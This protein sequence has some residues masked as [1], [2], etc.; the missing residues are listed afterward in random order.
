MTMDRIG[1]STTTYSL[2]PSE[3]NLATALGGDV[4]AQIAASMLHSARE[5][6]DAASDARHA[7]EAQIAKEEKEQ[8]R[9]MREQ[10]DRIRSAGY[11][12]AGSAFVGSGLQFVGAALGPET[13]TGKSLHAGGDMT[14]AAGQVFATSDR[15][16]ASIHEQGATRAEQIADTEKRSFS[17]IDAATDEARDLARTALDMLRDARQGENE[18]NRSTLYL[19]G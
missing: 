7:T 19:R 16:A 6:R 1:G 10:A 3:D 14:K 12:E 18:A 8:I 11:W 5:A 2:L 17:E 9:H 13:A 15:F 4:T